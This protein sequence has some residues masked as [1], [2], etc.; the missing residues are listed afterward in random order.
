MIMVTSVLNLFKRHLGKALLASSL[1][2]GSFANAQNGNLGQ[3]LGGYA[4][5]GKY[6]IDGKDHHYY[7]SNTGAFW[8]IAKANALGLGGYLATLTSQG[9]NDAVTTWVVGKTGY[10]PYANSG[11]Y[12]NINIPWIG[13]T[14]DAA[15]G[16]TEKNWVWTNGEHCSDFENWDK[17]TPEPNNFPGGTF[18]NYGTLLTFNTTKLGKW[19]DWFNDWQNRYIVEFGPN[20]CIPTVGNQGCTLGYWKNHVEDWTAPFTPTTKL[21]SAS[22][23][24]F[25][26]VTS[27]SSIAGDNLMT[28]LNYGGG[29]GDLGGAK[30]LLRQAVA[31]LLNSAH[32]DVD[33]PLSTAQVISMTNS[34]LSQNRA[35]MLNL[36]TALDTYN[37]LHGNSLCGDATTSTARAINPG[38]QVA[39]AEKAFAVS[40]YPNPSR[41]A[42][43][44]QINGLTSETVSVKV[45]DATGRL[46]EQRTNLAANQV[47]SV[48]NTYKAGLY[49]IEVAQ[50][51]KKQQLKMVK[52]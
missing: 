12:Q 33:Y 2:L 25:A 9:E 11:D 14:D 8:P 10:A 44:L 46:V 18:E 49:Y 22:T 16:T 23:F 37:N 5:L 45:T 41:A 36:A 6:V 29:P 4:Y 32:A 34:A 13:Y 30:T 17:E 15:E 50:G 38:A 40:G 31:A 7:L 24:S 48:G 39:T 51:A 47:L 21:N 28:A 52:Q 1:L 35:A 42:F 26:G 19:N 43:N 20:P 3:P 27:L